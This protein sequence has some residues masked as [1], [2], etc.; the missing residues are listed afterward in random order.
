MSDTYKHWETK[1]IKDKYKDLKFWAGIFRSEQYFWEKIGRPDMRVLDIGCA[2]GNLFHALKERFKQ[3]DYVGVDGSNSLI[4]RAKEL[5]KEAVFIN[6]DV[7]GLDKNDVKEK[8]DVVVATG[9]WQHEPKYKELLGIMLNYAKDGGYVLFD[10][11]L[12]HHQQTLDDIN[13]AYGDHGDHKVYYIILNYQDFIDLIQNKA[14]ILQKVEFCGYY[15]EVNFSVRL[16]K[17]VKEKVC[18]SH[19]LLQKKL[20]PGDSLTY[21]VNLPEEFDKKLI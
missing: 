8:F 7:F 9:V 14:G 21:D 18:S 12:F 4:N 11:K 16:P 17:S 10:V 2:T 6:K 13:I 19:I 5:T 20:Q 3:V 15:T 1:F